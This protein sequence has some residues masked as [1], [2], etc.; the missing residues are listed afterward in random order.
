MSEQGLCVTEVRNIDKRKSVITLNEE[1]KFSL[2][3]SEVKKYA[4]SEGELITQEQYRIIFEELLPARAKQRVM[5]ILRDSERSASDIRMKLTEGYYPAD[6]IDLVVCDMEDRGYIDDERYA[7]QFISRKCKGKS[8]NMI[9]QELRFHG[10]STELIENCLSELETE[11]SV[12]E[13]QQDIIRK[14]FIK[15]RYDFNE[16]MPELKNKIF[17]SLMRKGFQMDDILRVYREQTS[18]YKNYS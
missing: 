15:R 1:V 5:Y 11:L 14:E 10:V 18:E 3:H 9:R 8:L 4:I 2:Y 13:C 7:R 16:E 6:I 17:A 12:E